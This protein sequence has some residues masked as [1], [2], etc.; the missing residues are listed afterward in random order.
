[1]TIKKLKLPQISQ[2]FLSQSMR[3][4]YLLLIIFFYSCASVMSP[5]G[6]DID[7]VPPKL[8]KTLP[9]DLTGLS[10]GEK[11]ISNLVIGCDGQSSDTAK[12]A[13]NWPEH[14][15]RE[16]I[17]DPINFGVNASGF[18]LKKLSRRRLRCALLL[19]SA[20]QVP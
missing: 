12:F 10:S 3:N 15:L 2:M 1:M 18:S 17:Q 9:S 19:F 13:K 5:T 11:I 6:G 8:E 7:S 14:K 20:R 16:Y 4:A